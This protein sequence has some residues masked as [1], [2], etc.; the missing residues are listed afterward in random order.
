MQ[1]AMPLAPA[2]ETLPSLRAQT[3]PGAE[4]EPTATDGSR[5]AADAPVLVRLLQFLLD[6]DT[7]DAVL[8]RAAVGLGLLTEISWA[9]LDGVERADLA[10]VAI[11]VDGEAHRI[12]VALVEP[13]NERAR[14]A[15][16]GMLTLVEQTHARVVEIER[17]RALA[18]TDH[19]TGLWNRRGFEPLLDQALARAARTG[20]AVAL[21]LVDVDRFKHVNDEHGHA[22]GDRVLATVGASLAGAIRPT[23]VATRLGGDEF[24]VLLS[25]ADAQGARLVCERIRRALARDNPLTSR[26]VTLSFGVADLADLGSP[27]P[28]RL[29][30]EMWLA[31]ADAA[32]YEAKAAGRDTIVCHGA[33]IAVVED[34]NTQPICV[35]A[36]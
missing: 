27:A 9:E 1:L 7:G 32:L 21:V 29:G 31:A 25:G 6:A 12:D 11:D 34:D 24:A 19:L 33:V 3:R 20:E 14:A 5:A 2:L 10:S 35:R 17:L 13:S 28:G 26:G 8:H 15:V 4:P 30:R 23:D 18:T 22:M 16:Q 36:S